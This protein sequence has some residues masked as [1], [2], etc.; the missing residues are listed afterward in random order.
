MCVCVARI[1]LICSG[2]WA[3]PGSHNA[4]K[5]DN[6]PTLILFILE[7]APGHRAFLRVDKTLGL[8]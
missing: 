8:V 5:T 6:V 3:T 1:S 7:G 4:T 2:L